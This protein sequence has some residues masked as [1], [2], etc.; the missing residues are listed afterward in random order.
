MGLTKTFP[1]KDIPTSGANI[2]SEW[3][4]AHNPLI[5]RVQ[6]KDFAIA[7]SQTHSAGAKT[8]VNITGSLPAMS[9]GDY[10]YIDVAAE[11][12]AGL[13]QLDANVTATDTFF[14]INLAF[15]SDCGVGFVNLVTTYANYW[16]EAKYEKY[17]ISTSTWSSFGTITRHRADATGLSKI[18]IN[19]TLKNTVTM[20]DD[21]FNH[22]GFV[23][24][25]DTNIS[26]ICGVF[27][28]EV[29]NGITGAWDGGSQVSL[30]DSAMQ[31][32]NSNGSNL[33]EFVPEGTG[34]TMANF[35]SDFD[36]PTYWE[37]LPFDLSFIYS[38]SLYS[39]VG[40]LTVRRVEDRASDDDNITEDV[41]DTTQ[42]LLQN[43][44]LLSGS[45]TT[46]RIKVYLAAKY[47]P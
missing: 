45:F 28:R 3:W 7:S 6:R 37:G 2:L 22:S 36:V 41:I 32:G 47:I 13:Y 15:T 21:V 38:S 33:K 18:D 29:Y 30:T 35:V 19:V 44:M 10:I 11:I 4:A 8:Q 24:V 43:R 12:P 1:T 16:I 39:D 25:Y 31:A 42:A 5:V 26:A 27:F 23:N 9:A 46:D 14:V 34:T 17:D 20:Q 40:V